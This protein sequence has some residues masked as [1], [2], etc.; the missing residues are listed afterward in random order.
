M[1]GCF[2]FVVLAALCALFGFAAGAV[3]EPIRRRVRARPTRRG[4]DVLPPKR[5]DPGSDPDS[6]GGKR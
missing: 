2:V 5:P 4:F 3:T 1:D 6:R